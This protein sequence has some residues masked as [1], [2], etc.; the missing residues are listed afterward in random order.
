MPSCVYEYIKPN[1]FLRK[2]VAVNLFKPGQYLPIHT[3]IFGRYLT[4]H[5]TKFEDVERWIVMLEDCVPGQMLQIEKNVFGHWKAGDCFGFNVQ[6]II[7]F[8]T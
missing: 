2:F 3:D 4:I 6:K 8:I 7:L 1:I 5:D